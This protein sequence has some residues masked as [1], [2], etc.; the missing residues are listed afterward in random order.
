MSVQNFPA[1]DPEWDLV[2]VGIK[3]SVKYLRDVM[4]L[5]AE[6]SGEE[7]SMVADVLKTCIY[8]LNH[9]RKTGKLPGKKKR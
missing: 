4:K 7:H 6:S 2:K 3:D 9:L 1:P 5:Y 8:D